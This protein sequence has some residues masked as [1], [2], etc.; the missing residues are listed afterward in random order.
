MLLCGRG[1]ALAVRVLR[2]QGAE[3]LFHLVLLDDPNRAKMVLEV[4]HLDP[5]AEARD[6]NLPVPRHPGCG[7]RLQAAAH[8]ISSLFYW[9]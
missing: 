3:A 7:W 4:R 2:T 9:L 5:R 8:A 6:V 1:V